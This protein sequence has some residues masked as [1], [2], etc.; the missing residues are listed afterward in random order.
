MAIINNKKLKSFL[1]P[2]SKRAS[3]FETIISLKKRINMLEI[4]QSRTENYLNNI[5]RVIPANIYWKDLNSVILGGN[6]SHA[7][8]AGFA[9]PKEVVGKTEYDFVWKEQADEI[10]QNDQQIMRSG[11]GCQ[12]E[13][14]ATLSDG[15]LHTFLT[16]KDPLRDKNGYVIGIIGVSTDITELKELQKEL[17][18]A[19]TLSAEAALRV[20]NAKAIAEEEMRKTIMVLVGDIVHD[21]R[22]P[23]TTIKAIADLLEKILPAFLEIAE[24]AKC[25]GAEKIN[26]LNQN[27][28]DYLFSKAPMNDIQASITMMDDFISTTLAELA[29]AHKAASAELTREQLTKNSCQ[30]IINNTVKAYPF[31]ESE[32]NKIKLNITYDF[33]F[34]VNSILIMKLLF[35]LIKNALEQIALT[36]QGEITIS[37]EKESQY[38]L[39]RIKDTAG[40]ASPEVVSQLFN[41][42]FTTKRNGTGIGLAFCKKTM[43]SFGGDIACHSV[44]GEY[45]E[46]ILKF[47]VC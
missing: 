36:G 28:W 12:L 11:I 4:S 2:F 38:N 29:N 45:M 44:Y 18:A 25:L 15:K 26:L 24:E 6:L 13:E 42:Y 8:Q 43:I 40:G 14:T 32:K 41:G 19:K 30:R 31:S 35:N 9:D 33:H 21:L 1:R 16:C 7:N 46:F 39:I 20:S 17:L 47:P 3:R 37:T 22:T 10:I 23:L 34:M 27:S 5:I